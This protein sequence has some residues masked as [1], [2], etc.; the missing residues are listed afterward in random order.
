MNETPHYSYKI[1]GYLFFATLAFFAILYWKERMLFAQSADASFHLLNQ[2]QFYIQYGRIGAIPSQLLPWLLIKLNTPMQWVLISYSVSFIILYFGVFLLTTHWMRSYSAGFLL[3]FLLVLGNKQ[4]FYHP[5]SEVTQALAFSTLF[6]GWLY[7]NQKINPHR[8]RLIRTAT[9]LFFIALSISTHPAVFPVLIFMLIHHAI[10]YR[11][12][13]R[14]PTYVY[15]SGMVLFFVIKLLI[16]NDFV[17]G[18]THFRGLYSLEEFFYVIPDVRGLLFYFTQ[19]GDLYFVSFSILLVTLIWLSLR[20]HKKELLFYS[21]FLALYFVAVAY[22]FPHSSTNMQMEEIYQP[23]NTILLI[24][25]IYIVVKPTRTTYV[26]KLSLYLIVFI[27][28]I[29]KIEFS[30]KIFQ[31]RMRY[32]STKIDQIDTKKTIISPFNLDANTLKEDWALAQETL[33]LTSYRA[34][35]TP[36][37]LLISNPANSGKLTA[38][39]NSL[40]LYRDK[41]KQLH[42]TKLNPSY[43]R[44]ENQQY[45][46]Y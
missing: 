39:A 35:T 28:S 26:L 22:L 29:E 44:L 24:P 36:K 30:H 40:F 21:G 7:H 42:S 11:R 19:I 16:T 25:F 5:T 12:Y 4:L 46:T 1:A 17:I 2:E 13:L 15:L 41:Q 23:F 34:E 33:L 27:A 6:I 18:E 43:F 37:T 32:L 3:I 45:R 14:W 10:H 20:T 31:R 9:G 8:P 38:H